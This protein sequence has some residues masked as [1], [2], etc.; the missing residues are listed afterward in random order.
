MKISKIA[1]VTG[2]NRGLGFEVARQLGENGFHVFL[3]ARHREAGKKAAAE[4]QKQN[5]SVSFIELDTANPESIQQAARA[6]A[7]QIDHLD[8][9]IN[10]AAILKDENLSILQIDSALM[11]KTLVT[12]AIGPLLVAQAFHALLA[13]SADARI[14]NVSSGSGSLNEMRTYAPAYSI[15]KTALNAVTVQLA[16]AFQSSGIAV[17]SVCP[18]WV[19]TDMGGRGA[20]RSVEKGADTIIWLATAAPKKLTGK[21]LRDRKIIAW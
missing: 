5:L 12:N 16:F 6:V 15:S 14:V 4:L 20:P 21:F 17:N 11:Q 18:G 9:L 2:A 10:N 19:R 3:S 8:V 1:L 13:K 7:A